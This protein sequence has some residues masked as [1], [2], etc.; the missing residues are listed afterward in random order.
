MSTFPRL[1]LQ[2]Y[3]GCKE[4]ALQSL[5][6]E[7]LKHTATSSLFRQL[8]KTGKYLHPLTDKLLK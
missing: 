4:A 3:I 2:I 8:Q 1:T 7:L 6:S 5:H